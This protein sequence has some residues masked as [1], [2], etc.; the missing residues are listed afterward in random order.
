MKLKKQQ[1]NR[2]RKILELKKSEV[3]RI[4]KEREVEIYALWSMIKVSVRRTLI[5]F[6]HII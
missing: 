3:E 5:N 2:K 4:N 1:E 6:N